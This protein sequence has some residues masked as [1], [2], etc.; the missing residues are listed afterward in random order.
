MSVNSRTD[1]CTIFI[2]TC[3]IYLY[4]YSSDY[5]DD[6]YHVEFKKCCKDYIQYESIT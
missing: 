4:L 1:K 2:Q 5:M 3:N 6:L